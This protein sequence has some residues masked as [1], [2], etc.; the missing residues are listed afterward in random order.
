MFAAATTGRGPP[1]PA[2]EV[3]AR[4]PREHRTEAGEAGLVAAREVCASLFASHLS[5]P[6]QTAMQGTKSDI[7]GRALAV[8]Y[9]TVD[10]KYFR[11]WKIEVLYFSHGF[12][13]RAE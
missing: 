12:E 6:D 9:R 8:I 7:I 13:M 4:P 1:F 10:S 3:P 11:E 5:C 2:A